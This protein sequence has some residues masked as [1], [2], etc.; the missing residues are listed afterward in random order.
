VVDSNDFQGGIAGNDEP[1]TIGANQWAS[2]DGVADVVQDFFDGEIHLVKLTATDAA[3][4]P[5]IFD[6]DGDGS[7][8]SAHSVTFD[9]N[10]DGSAER[11]GWADGGDGLLGVDVDG[12]GRIAS[13]AE[14][15]SPQ[16]VAGA[17][18][19]LDALASFD[20]NHDGIIDDQD[21]R[22]GEL[23]IWQDGN[24]NAVTDPGELTS[25]SG[26]KIAAISLEAEGVASRDGAGNSVNSEGT[27]VLEDGSFGTFVEVMFAGMPDPGDGADA[28]AGGGVDYLGEDTSGEIA[29]LSTG[30][31]YI[32]IE[33]LLAPEG[34]AAH[35]LS[36]AAPAG[37]G[38]LGSARIE[39]SGGAGD[40]IAALFDDTSEAASPAV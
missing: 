39:E 21:D 6:L 2:G 15:V 9:F 20:S 19:S 5:I 18:T 14:L 40:A 3:N 16:M 23:V 29:G 30:G 34:W 13:G 33:A 25:L 36:D 22:F 1:I 12:D 32:D 37:E 8:F 31:D 38:G 17:A 7:A 10:G 26:L 4:D 27:Y 35:N 28:T 11:I 24:E